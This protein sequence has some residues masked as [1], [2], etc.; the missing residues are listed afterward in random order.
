MAAA[1]A[2]DVTD[3]IG[4]E[5]PAQLLGQGLLGSRHHTGRAIADVDF[6]ARV[7]FL[8]EIIERGDAQRDGVTNQKF[9]GYRLQ[10]V[11]NGRAR[12]VGASDNALE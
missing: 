10:V 7:F 9:P 4:F 1:Q 2:T 11:A 12:L 3:L 6:F 5:M 8:E